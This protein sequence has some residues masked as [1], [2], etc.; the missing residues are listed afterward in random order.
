MKPN[1][2]IITSTHFGPML[3]NRYDYYRGQD[4]NG[5]RGVGLDLMETNEYFRHEIDACFDMI[6]SRRAKFGDGVMVLDVGANIGTHT[7]SWATRM[8]GWGEVCAIEAQERIF[9]ALA[10]NITMNNCFNARAMWAAA[11]AKSGTMI[12]PEVDLQQ[13]A[14]FGGLSLVDGDRWD[15]PPSTRKVEISAVAIDDFRFQR[16]D[17]IKIDVQG[18]ELDVLK[19]AKET[20]ERCHPIIFAEMNSSVD[21]YAVAVGEGYSCRDFDGMNVLMESLVAIEK[22]A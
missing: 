19:G 2:F 11:A 3:A 1:P 5:W 4:G 6:C 17:F 10:G 16:L 18:M 8:H 9:Y 21:E 14:N 15:Q 20:I 12:V 22:A 13:P 7:V